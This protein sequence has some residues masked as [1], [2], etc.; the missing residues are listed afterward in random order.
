MTS[1]LVALLRPSF[2]IYD[3]GS[4]I[5]S[6][7]YCVC[8]KRWWQYLVSC[9]LCLLGAA[10]GSAKVQ[11][12]T[13]ILTHHYDGQ[14]T[15]WNPQETM[16]SPS[17]L[18]S[19]SFGL[20]I[21]VQVDDD[22][23]V[24]PLVVADRQIAGADGNRT[25]IYV[26]TDSNTVYAIDASTGEILLTRN[27]GPPVPQSA[28]G[29]CNNNGANIGIDA[30]PIIDRSTGLLY[31][32]AYTFDNGVPNYTLHALD[33]STLADAL[34]PA[35]V[36]ASQALSDGTIYTFDPATARQRA[37]LLETNGN[38]YAAFTSFCD[39]F[40]DRS[41]GWVLGWSASSLQPL[42]SNQLNDILA[43]SPNTFFLSSVWMSGS[44]PAVSSDGYLFF[45]TG[46]SDPGSYDSVQNLSESLVK[47]T[48]DLSSVV[49]FF[50]PS[51]VDS[52]DNADLD[53][54]AGGVL[55]LPPQSGSS[56]NLAVAAGKTG[57]M[58][59]IDQQNLGGITPGGPD[60]VLG[61]F[62]IGGC[63][64]APSYFTGADGVGRVVSS[65]GSSVIVW[66]IGV[67]PVTLVQE[68]NVSLDTG[69]DPGFFTAVSSNG[70]QDG[71]A[72]IWAVSRPLDASPAIVSLFAF[73]ARSGSL[74]FSAPAGTWLGQ[75]NA[76]IVPVVAN[77][78][79]YVGSSMQLAIFGLGSSGLQVPVVAR[80][81]P[82]VSTAKS[83]RAQANRLSGTVLELNGTA[84][85]L[86]TR[87]GGVV[88]VDA[89]QAQK[90]YRS[91][92]LVAGEAITALGTYDT[93]G[94]LMARTVLRA[95][96]SPAL[97]PPDR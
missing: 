69:Q 49:D 20:L 72:L 97:W 21:T 59:L 48:S 29:G 64:C 52:L 38:I 58:Y 27:L 92:V 25:V 78:Q 8:R 47:I 51:E 44:G 88:R 3:G 16:L 7:F 19:G 73:D 17:S 43:A 57:R 24:Q 18:S 37:A 93:Q 26:G 81:K 62:D 23:N 83:V 11:A 75:G 40:A 95:K 85:T 50:T 46:N 31:I 1:F 13:D 12:A 67:S 39:F 61:I 30:T 71:T 76:N 5:I 14:R 91:V 22:I 34:Q 4:S 9:A 86:E 53:F 55:L 77:G 79:V 74:V 54:G 96:D 82:V 45:A 65:G 10:A 63:F 87:T 70:T 28:V 66:K 94:V 32:I 35:I 56:L 33:L 6:L 15:G 90:A 42:P 68:S 41:R 84:L 80:A 89:V 2:A 36:T 60:N